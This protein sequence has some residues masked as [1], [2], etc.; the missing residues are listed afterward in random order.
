MKVSD[1]GSG[2]DPGRQRAPVDGS[3]QLAGVVGGSAGSWSRGPANLEVRDGVIVALR[4]AL[5]VSPA[6]GTATHEPAGRRLVLVPLLVNAH[7]HGRGAGNVLAGI[8]DGPLEPWI[9]SLR[10]HGGATQRALVGDACKAMLA[11]GVGATVLCVNPQ[12][13]DIDTEVVAAARAVSEI[14]MRAAVVYPFADAMASPYGRT[15]DQPGWAP[16]EIAERLERFENVARA[17]EGPDIELQ[18]GPV[19][20]QWVSE[21]SLAAIGEHARR[22]RRRVHLHLLESRAQRAWADT[23]YP[24]GLLRFLT[25]VGLLGPHVCCAHGTQLRDEEIAEVATSGAVLA[26]NASSNLRLASGIPPVA[27]AAASAGALGAGLD[28]LALGDDGDYWTELRLLRG[29]EQAQAGAAVAAGPMLERFVA[30]GRRALGACAPGVPGEG[31]VADFVLLDLGD[32]AHLMD[33]AE[34]PPAEIVLAA[35]TPGRVREVWVGGRAVYRQAVHATT[36]LEGDN[37]HDADSADAA[38]AGGKRCASTR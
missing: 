23:T 20:P 21:A 24:D 14:G 32:H 7:D 5:P 12:G 33:R 4:S 22:H 6:T 26:L 13:P 8:P 10:R 34:W 30:G 29:L 19:G 35:A 37:H 25:T 31:A 36:G 2:S 3:W 17:I 11:S 16:G 15:R 1:E 18:L 9:E 28:G 38:E 27:Q